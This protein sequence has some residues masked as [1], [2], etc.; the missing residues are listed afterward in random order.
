M[1]IKFNTL[2]DI[3]KQSEERNGTDAPLTIGHFHN[4][5]KLVYKVEQKKEIQALKDHEEI[6][7]EIYGN[8]G[9]G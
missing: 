5:I 6:I 3:L 8:H 2:L 4:I 9:Q 7:E 1:E